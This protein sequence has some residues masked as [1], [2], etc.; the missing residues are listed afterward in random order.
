MFGR[1][2]PV[3]QRRLGEP[4]S[5]GASA[6]TARRLDGVVRAGL[7]TRTERRQSAWRIFSKPSA[8]ADLSEMERAAQRRV[9]QLSAAGARGFEDKAMFER[10]R[11]GII[12]RL[13]LV[14]QAGALALETFVK[15]E[16]LVRVVESSD[17]SVLNELIIGGFAGYQL[18]H[19]VS[20]GA[21]L[22]GN[23]TLNDLEGSAL[24]VEPQA[25]AQLG[26]VRLALGCLVPIVNFQDAVIIGVRL[27]AGARF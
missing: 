8:G 5:S 21:R 4:V 17:P 9:V 11:L 1:D 12:P 6:R 25:R 27:A 3:L 13:Q 15:F 18:A 19:V 26:P 24:V 14:H 10:G 16:S 22:W 2:R 7:P 20:L 23:L